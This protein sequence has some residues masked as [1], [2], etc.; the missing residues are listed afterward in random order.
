[1]GGDKG[2]ISLDRAP[3]EPIDEYAQMSDALDSDFPYFEDGAGEVEEIPASLPDDGTLFY[4]QSSFTFNDFP[5]ADGYFGFSNDTTYAYNGK[6]SSYGAVVAP[7]DY[8][9]DFATDRVYSYLDNFSASYVHLCEKQLEI[10]GTGDLTDAAYEEHGR[11]FP[12]GPDPSNPSPTDTGH[13]ATKLMRWA[14]GRMVAFVLNTGIAGGYWPPDTPGPLTP[15]YL[16]YDRGAV[17]RSTDNGQS[18]QGQGDVED[19]DGN[20]A[21]LQ[22]ATGSSDSPRNWIYMPPDPTGV[23]Y[24][25]YKDRNSHTLGFGDILFSPNGGQNIF[26]LWSAGGDEGYTFPWIGA[27][28]L[29]VMAMDMRYLS[30]PITWG[31]SLMWSVREGSTGGIFPQ[32]SNQIWHCRRLGLGTFFFQPIVTQTFSGWG[33]DLGSRA[34]YTGQSVLIGTD[35]Y[36]VYTSTGYTSGRRIRALARVINDTGSEQILSTDL[37]ADLFG[38]SSSQAQTLLQTTLWSSGPWVPNELFLMTHHDD[39]LGPYNG[40]HFFKSLD[41]GTTWEWLTDPALGNNGA[42][43]PIPMALS[44]G[45]PEEFIYVKEN[46][47]I[48]WNIN[49]GFGPDYW[50]Y[51]T[52]DGGYTWHPFAH[53]SRYT[54]PG[55]PHPDPAG[56]RWPAS[57]GNIKGSFYYPTACVRGDDYHIWTTTCP[58]D[59]DPAINKYTDLV[60]HVLEITVAPEDFTF[61][62]ICSSEAGFIIRESHVTSLRDKLLELNSKVFTRGSNGNIK[63][64]IDT[65][66]LKSDTAQVKRKIKASHYNTLR[67]QFE[68]YI[69]PKVPAVSGAAFYTE[70]VD[71]ADTEYQVLAA[72]PNAQDGPGGTPTEDASI[73]IR[74]LIAMRKIIQALYTNGWFCA[75]YS[76]CP[77]QTDIAISAGKK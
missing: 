16:T 60:G 3:T 8:Y 61:Y 70:G 33:P 30:D 58:D 25:P 47:Y 52:E 54:W 76:Y 26:V 22:V 14:N 66:A 39:S 56:T 72:V 62:V 59:G 6:Q 37:G 50:C 13:R 57:G 12:S 24:F 67:S 17:W 40:I 20:P 15:Y 71:L 36:Y 73:K 23:F 10:S 69:K 1:M 74:T 42:S 2:D 5:G 65:L 43:G 46:T 27:S 75:C 28:S 4:F 29:H 41:G 34:I 38:A 31:A 51:M 48:I 9:I 55:Y 7:G 21:L 18:W 64:G 45:I 53:Y 19:L 35:N 77:C 68:D 11:L 44:A 32:T 49:R 63:F